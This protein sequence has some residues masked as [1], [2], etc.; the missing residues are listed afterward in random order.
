MENTPVSYIVPN[1]NIEHA[2]NGFSLFA[3]CAVLVWG[4]VQS[5]IEYYVISVNDIQPSDIVKLCAIC[6]SF[7]ACLFPAFFVTMH[8]KQALPFVHTKQGK[9]TSKNIFFLFY[10][11]MKKSCFPALASLPF[12]LYPVHAR[13]NRAAV[14]RQNKRA[15][16]L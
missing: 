15:C 5:C 10:R 1:C 11:K 14:N 4:I 13:L 12:S 16:T 6:Q 2:G 8:K 7:F 3:L 9:H